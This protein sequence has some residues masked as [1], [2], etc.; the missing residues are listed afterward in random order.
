MGPL[1]TPEPTLHWRNIPDEALI[2]VDTVVL[3]YFLERHPQYYPAAKTLFQ[4]I[5][6]GSLHAVMASLVLTELLVPAYRE[7]ATPVATHLIDVLQGFPHLK[8]VP[9]SNDIAILAARLRAR[10]GLRTPDA[11]HVATALHE[12]CSGLVTNDLELLRV[13]SELTIWTGCE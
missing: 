11:I 4:R 5:E 9:L 13:Q 3:V 2:A 1:T 10:Y 12:Q 8:I 7:Q 6:E